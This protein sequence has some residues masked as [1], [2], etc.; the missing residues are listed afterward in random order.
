MNHLESL[1][2]WYSSHCD[3]GWEQS[4]GIKI[5]TLDNPGWSL[6]IDLAETELAGRPFEPIHRGDSESDLNWVHCKVEAEQFVALGGPSS[7]PELLEIFLRW[8]APED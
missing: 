2:S 3:G 1:I 4:F 7:L 5:D 8:A 6:R